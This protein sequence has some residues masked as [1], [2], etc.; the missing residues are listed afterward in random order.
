MYRERKEDYT[1]EYTICYSISEG[2][3][4][5]FRSLDVVNGNVG[6]SGFETFSAGEVVDSLDFTVIVHVRVASFG[7]AVSVTGLS[8]GG[9]TVGVTVSVLTVFVLCV[10]LALDRGNCYGRGECRCGVH[11]RCGRC[12]VD[13]VWGRCSVDGVWGRCGVHGVWGW[14]GV[15]EHWSN[16]WFVVS[17]Y[18][19]VGSGDR[20]W[21][22]GGQ[23][24]RRWG[25]QVVDD[26][27]WWGGE[28]GVLDGDDV[29]GCWCGG[30]T[31]NQCRVE[32]SATLLTG[33]QEDGVLWVVDVG[34]AGW[35]ERL[36][37]LDQW[38]SGGHDVRRALDDDR[39]GGCVVV[40][41]AGVGSGDWEWCW[42]SG[43]VVW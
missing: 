37:E 22:W 29:C 40:D 36:G 18:A 28:F 33:G 38:V 10:E 35:G 39:L 32:S 42:G 3:G 41:D 5:V 31:G 6:A 15:S 17:G 24:V 12:S 34:S 30:V 13:G 26:W 16:C 21:C 19:G 14:G 20:S 8:L 1:I 11:G 43:Q 27:C 25:G 2:A 4:G 9:C 7:L 23:V